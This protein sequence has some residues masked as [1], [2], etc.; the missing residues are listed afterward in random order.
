M[1][2]GQNEFNNYSLEQEQF[3]DENPISPYL[4]D[5]GGSISL[6]HNEE[7][8]ISIDVKENV[9]KLRN[10]EDFI[11]EKGPIYE[12]EG[13]TSNFL[14]RKTNRPQKNIFNDVNQTTESI[15][16]KNSKE[17]TDNKI[18]KLKAYLI[19]GYH[20]TLNE[21]LKEKGKQLC[22]L[23]TNI[24]ENIGKEYNLVMK[25]IPFRVFYDSDD[26]SIKYKKAIY[27]TNNSGVIN[28]I[29]KAEKDDTIKKL[30]KLLDLK[31]NDIY[32]IFIKE[33]EDDLYKNFNN[34]KQFEEYVKNKPT[35]TPKSEEYVKNYVYGGNNQKGF[36]DLNLDKYFEGK[37]PRNRGKKNEKNKKSKNNV[38]LVNFFMS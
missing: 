9:P 16:N 7:Y 20:D 32:E 12:I 30:N 18:I 14:N 10:Q 15:K 13:K 6:I 29:D 36:K 37:V 8:N 22:K 17:R 26:I 35:T 23:N 33:K 27:K 19:N 5:F 1:R 24:K 11:P 3:Q 2:F 31:Y 21:L 28:Y 4:P 34:I 38:S 25:E